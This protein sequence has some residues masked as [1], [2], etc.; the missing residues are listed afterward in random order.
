[1]RPRTETG[2]ESDDEDWEDELQLKV[3]QLRGILRSLDPWLEPLSTAHPEDEREID[4]VVRARGVS[5][6]MRRTS[7]S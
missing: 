2:S 5:M 4:F 6:T 7:G 1:M 3:K